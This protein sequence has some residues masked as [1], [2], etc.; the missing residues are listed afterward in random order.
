MTGLSQIEATILQTLGSLESRVAGM[1]EQLSE[2]QGVMSEMGT[3][4]DWYTTAE[5]AELV[6]VTRQ[7]IQDRWCNQG[8]IECEKCEATGKWRIPGHE[9]D[10][11]RRR[12]R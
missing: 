6:G 7:T 4:K 12:G 9:Y 10:R 1:S 11:L 8:R 3:L 2:M 5:V